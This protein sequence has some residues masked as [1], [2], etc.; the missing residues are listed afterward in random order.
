[1]GVI[2]LLLR[3]DA[4][5]GLGAWCLGSASYCAAVPSL[6]NIQELVEQPLVSS[7]SHRPNPRDTRVL[8]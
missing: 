2:L 4:V 7:L 3:R 8:R 5:S 1:M 6:I